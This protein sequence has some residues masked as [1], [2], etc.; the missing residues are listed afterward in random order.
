MRAFLILCFLAAFVGGGM[1]AIA[2]ALTAS[3]AWAGMTFAFLG[4]AYLLGETATN[5]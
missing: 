4:C 5:I 3:F 1:C 2:Y